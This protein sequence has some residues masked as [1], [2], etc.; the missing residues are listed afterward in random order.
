[1]RILYVIR[2][3][4][5]IFNDSVE[6]NESVSLS[7]RKGLLIYIMCNMCDMPESNRSLDLEHSN[8]SVKMTVKQLDRAIDDFAQLKREVVTRI[9][10]CQIELT[11]RG[12]K[13]KYLT[14]SAW[15]W[16]ALVFNI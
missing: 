1:M 4:T 11:I 14:K 7:F 10:G 2:I 5:L 15:R 13:K 6:C 3:L 16:L 9:A 8:F 12:Q